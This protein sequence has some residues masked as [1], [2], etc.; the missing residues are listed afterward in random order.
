[1]SRKERPQRQTRLIRN[2]PGDVMRPPGC[3][4]APPIASKQDSAAKEVH[5]ACYA[6][7]VQLANKPF[8]VG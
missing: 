1:M 2:T 7:D 3:R 4:R 5:D 8:H 6:V